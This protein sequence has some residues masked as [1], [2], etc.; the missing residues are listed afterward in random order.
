MGKEGK[1]DGK[2]MTGWDGAGQNSDECEC[3]LDHRYSPKS[4]EHI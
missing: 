1:W 2:V 3:I 4:M